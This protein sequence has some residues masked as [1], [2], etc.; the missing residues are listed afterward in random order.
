MHNFNVYE[1]VMLVCFGTSWPFA[2]LKT[3][4]ESGREKSAVHV[5]DPDRL[6]QRDS[7]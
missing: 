2:L 4:R 5:F 6:Y 3:I 7:E 1:A